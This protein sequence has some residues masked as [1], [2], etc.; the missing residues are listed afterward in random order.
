MTEKLFSKITERV[1]TIQSKIDFLTEIEMRIDSILNMLV[2]DD[3]L[4][5]EEEFP[6]EVETVSEFHYANFVSNT[7]VSYSE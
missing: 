6:E 4:D 2:E 3:E 7:A 1:D 5:L